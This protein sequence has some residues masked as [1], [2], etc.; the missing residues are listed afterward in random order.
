[1]TCRNC[2][3]V[4]MNCYTWG[5]FTVAQCLEQIKKTPIRMVEL[6]AEQ[7][8]PGSLIPE[9]MLNAP[10][11][12]AWQYSLP[13]LKDLLARD[14]FQVD[15]VAV[16]G[17]T[18]YPGSAD[19]I[20]QRIDFACALGA[21]IIVLGCHHKALHHLTPGSEAQEQKDAR[22]FM[23]S[24][25]RDVGDY[26]AG[27]NI[28][29]ALEIHGGVTAN[30]EEAI[31]TMEEVNRKNVGINF[32]TANILYYND[33]LDSDGAAEA[34]ESLA[35]HVFHVHLKDIVRGKTRKENVLPRLGTGE[36]DFRRVFDILHA[37]NFY[38]P[39]SFEVETF[40]GATK[41]DDIAPY[42]EDLLASIEYIRS[43]GELGIESGS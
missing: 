5:R 17:F 26:A 12:G 29:I 15:S 27:K 37:A 8:R 21:G 41:S 1:M 2:F 42:H 23:Y 11:G 20:K 4:S 36:V 18:G 30:A 16:F 14:G 24:M 40:H 34:L 7:T 39:F 10:L 33:A 35:G 13:D 3:S 31:R 43:I 19:F 22:A 9:L 28:K 32:D 38:G 6:P 25:L